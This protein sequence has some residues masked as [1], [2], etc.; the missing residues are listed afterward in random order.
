MGIWD[1]IHSATYSAYSA[2]EKAKQIAPDLTAVTAACR[3]SCN[4]SWTAVTKVNNVIM[5]NVVPTLNYYVNDEEGREKTGRVAVSFANHAAFEGLKWVPGGVPMW[6]IV[7]RSLRDA[8]TE[9]YNK[10]LGKKLQD[11]EDRIDRLEIESS[12]HKNMPDDVKL[13]REAR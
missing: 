5:E 10:E 12:G 2:T 11:L 13:E 1:S 8:K 3:S 7:S 6:N 9:D 4:Y